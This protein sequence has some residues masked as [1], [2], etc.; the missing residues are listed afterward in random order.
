MFDRLFSIFRS[1]EEKL[2][3]YLLD[4][5]KLSKECIDELIR[6]VEEIPNRDRLDEVARYIAALEKEADELTRKMDEEVVSGAII[7]SIIS[8]LE[9]LLDR[10]DNVM[11]GIY[12][13]SRELRRGASIWEV[14][15]RV[16][17]F[18]RD[19]FIKMLRITQRSIDILLTLL[20]NAPRN[21]DVMRSMGLRIEKLEEEVD[22]I[23]DGVMDGLY[24]LRDLAPVTFHHITALTYGIDS[25]LDNMKDVAVLVLTISN[26][27][28]S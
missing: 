4:H 5:V 21:K 19:P 26:A 17:E 23:K 6:V 25:I 11:D 27:I 8:D 18:L 1:R 20:Q 24:T 2:F 10:I 14:D 3:L 9:L 16:V 28:S 13:L 22:D 7:P 15:P 12:F